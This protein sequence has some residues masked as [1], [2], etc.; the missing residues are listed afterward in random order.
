M[1]L[2]QHQEDS[3]TLTV[4]GMLQQA[5][6]CYQAARFS[7]ADE[8]YHSIL[9]IDPSH[10]G[11]HYNLGLMNMKTGK[12]EMGLPHLQA[13]WEEDPSIGQYWLTLTECLL[14]LDHADDALMIIEDA[15]IPVSY[16]HLTLPTKRIV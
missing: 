1:S 13:A 9:Q 16:T 10:P 11:A 12:P 14:E 3:A 6:N 15:L 5:I 4:D 8:L 7:A 2:V